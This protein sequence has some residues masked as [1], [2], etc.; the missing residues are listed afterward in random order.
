MGEGEGVLGGQRV[1]LVGGRA[2]GQA[3]EF[4]GGFG[5]SLAKPGGGVQ[6]GA[7]GGAA[8]GQLIQAVQGGA[9]HVPPV[10]DHG[11]PAA[12]LLPEGDGHG[13]LQMGPAGL[14]DAGVLL[15]QPL[16]ADEHGLDGREE[17]LIQRRHRRDVQGGGEGV[18]GAL[19][20][21]HVV[22]GVQQGFPGLVVAVAGDDLVAVHVG[23]GAAAGLPHGQGEVVRQLP[24]PDG[25]AG[26]LD[27]GVARVIQL[28]QLVVG[29]G[30]GLLEHAE[31]GD[32]VGGHLL[33]PDGEVLKAPLGLRPPQLVCGDG[34][35][36]H[37]VVFHSVFQGDPSL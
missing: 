19:G 8:Q 32:E 26:G 5:G 25:L 33:L 10:L 13:V 31:G 9:D 3:G 11:A 28:A 17:P 22:V 4:C 27:E 16:Q 12:D 24:G 6:P 35:L 15:L 37:G 29:G 14:D 23:L 1:E 20:H 34:Y 30:A 18:V 7:H 2:E 21:V 36:A